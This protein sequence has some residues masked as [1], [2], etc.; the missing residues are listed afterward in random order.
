MLLKWK[1]E[2]VLGEAEAE[3]HLE[4]VVEAEEDSISTKKMLNV[5][6]AIN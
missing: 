1:K 2:Q 3:D 6:N 5:S 4:G